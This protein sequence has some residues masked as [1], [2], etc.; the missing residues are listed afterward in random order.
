MLPKRWA[1]SLDSK[2]TVFDKAYFSRSYVVHHL[3]F[4]RQIIIFCLRITFNIKL[5]YG[6]IRHACT[7]LK[8]IQY[9]FPK[10]KSGMGSVGSFIP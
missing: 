10:V 6:N 4:F 5:Y 1:L 2:Q 8:Q 9:P 3:Q 7:N